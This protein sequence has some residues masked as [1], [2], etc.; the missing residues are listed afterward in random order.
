MGPITEH[1]APTGIL[2]SAVPNLRVAG[3][4]CHS[5]VEYGQR[6]AFRYSYIFTICAC[7]SIEFGFSE[8]VALNCCNGGKSQ[9]GIPQEV[10]VDHSLTHSYHGYD[11]S[12]PEASNTNSRV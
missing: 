2:D 6:N 10:F 1:V 7:F 5:S 11:S 8:K 12:L 3:L 4:R 9:F